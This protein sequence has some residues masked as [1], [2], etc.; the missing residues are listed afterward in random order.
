[1]PTP[2]RRHAHFAQ[3]KPLY[4]SLIPNP[5]L[6]PRKFGVKND[7][8]NLDPRNSLTHI[9][10]HPLSHPQIPPGEFAPSTVILNSDNLPPLMRYHTMFAH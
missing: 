2:Q 8:T 1:M 4:A 7:E 6:L 5:D 9:P 10:L 3:P